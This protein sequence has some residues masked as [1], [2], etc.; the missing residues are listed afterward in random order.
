MI[1]VTG[2]T[3]HLG[4]FVVAELCAQGH[5]VACLARRPTDHPT[6]P[7]V[8]WERPVQTIACDLGDPAGVEAARP[9]LAQAEFVVHLA[10]HVPAQTS[11]NRPE[12][13]DATLNANVHGTIALLDALAG[14]R[15]LKGFVY[16]STFEVYGTPHAGPIDEDHPTE[17]VG[18]Y[19]VTKLCG[20]KYA[21]LAARTRGFACSSLR[22]PAIYGPGDTLSR[23]IGNFARAAADG[24]PIEIAGDGEDLR[25]LI[26]VTDAAEAVSQAI[27]SGVSGV[28]NVGSGR[29]YSIREMAEAALRA[30]DGKSELRHGDRVKPRLDYVLD[31]KRA[32]DELGWTP[33][34]SLED[35][36]RAQ[37]EWVRSVAPAG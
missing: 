26:F 16:A 7:G 30:G 27:A 2:G 31:V 11:A 3:G 12:D 32:R 29:G 9:T 21:A 28:F 1:V 24:T 23:A 33:R 8:A 15:K 14:S 25:E 13:A 5:D 20:E 17:P 35:G 34:T 10:A 22:L 6:I 18:Y 4:Q 19:G 36:V 37:L